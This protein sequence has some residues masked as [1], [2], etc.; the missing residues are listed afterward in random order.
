METKQAP[1]TTELK[2]ILLNKGW[3]D[4]IVLVDFLAKN[5]PDGLC[6]WMKNQSTTFL[7]G[8]CE[9]FRNW[10]YYRDVRIDPMP[11]DND[12]YALDAAIAKAGAA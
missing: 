10:S 9:P 1:K 2:S 12:V 3:G 6:Q 5:N 11:F 4:A 7:M 8:I